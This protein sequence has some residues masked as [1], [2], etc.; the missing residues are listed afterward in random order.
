[1]DDLSS[2]N[3]SYSMHNTLAEVIYNLAMLHRATPSALARYD[4][5]CQAAA[6]QVM[7][8]YST[9]FS[10]ATQLLSCTVRTDI[11]NLYAMVRTADEIVDSGLDPAEASILLDAYE[12]TVRTSPLQR[13]HTDPIIHA[14]ALSARRCGFRD[15]HIAAF[16]SSMRCDL[17]RSNHTA[18][19]FNSYVYGSAEVIGLLCLQV[20]FSG[21]SDFPN[22][23]HPQQ[24]LLENG[25][26]RLGAAFQKINFLRD[27]HEDYLDRGRIYF[28]QLANCVSLNEPKKNSIIADIRSDLAAASASIGLL[29]YTS[30]M[31]VSAATA[32]FSELT[33]I[34]AATP[35]EKLMHTRV[36]I[37]L[38]RKAYLLSRVAATSVWK[39]TPRHK[40]VP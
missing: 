3:P 39:V 8:H 18:E 14:Y 35:I 22:A 16:F 36:S 20:F 29:P 34:L 6:A 21:F 23:Q 27:L 30:R 7:R 25:A 15:E 5:S 28:P 10:A 32:L 38:T 11:R 12:N 26:R 33:D 13:F 40:D 17:T 37:P 1:M 24:E 9:S 4:Y 2:P 31:G 19:T